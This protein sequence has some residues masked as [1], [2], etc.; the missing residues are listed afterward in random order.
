MGHSFWI[1]IKKYI[2]KYTCEKK[3]FCLDLRADTLR[4]ND[5]SFKFESIESQLA[6]S[7]T[8][9]IN[10]KHL[11][12]LKELILSIATKPHIGKRL[13]STLIFFLLQMIK[14]KYKKTQL[15]SMGCNDITTASKWANVLGNS[16]NPLMLLDE[17]RNY[18]ADD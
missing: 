1:S 5:Q 17:N 15:Q 7:I 16:D 12:H 9:K 3:I 8:D 6:D 13:V 2:K 4:K 10:Y 14:I 11:S 18:K